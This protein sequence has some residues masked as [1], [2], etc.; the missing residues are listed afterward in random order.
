MPDNFHSQVQ[1]LARITQTMCWKRLVLL[2]EKQHIRRGVL[3]L[4]QQNQD[5]IIND[6]VVL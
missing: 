3:E 6:A 4:Q 1:C 5:K 2:K